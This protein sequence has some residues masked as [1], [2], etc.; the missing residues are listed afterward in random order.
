MFNYLNNVLN[1]TVSTEVG[2][3]YITSTVVRPDTEPE[4]VKF[5]EVVFEICERLAASSLHM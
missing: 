1:E 2:S 3:L 4:N 5:G